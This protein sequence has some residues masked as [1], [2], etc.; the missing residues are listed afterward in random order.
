M[1]DDGGQKISFRC[2]RRESMY[3]KHTGI[4]VFIFLLSFIISGVPKHSTGEVK[5]H[6]AD[7]PEEIMTVKVALG[8]V[9][10][11]PA[12]TFPVTGKL[13]KGDKVK[14][15]GNKDKWYMIRFHGDQVGW[16]HESLFFKTHKAQ[17]AGTGI[18]GQI[19]E[20][21]FEI[22][23]EGGEMVV[24]Q[25]NGYYPPK[26]FAIDKG[27]PRVVCDF[28]DTN[29]GAGIGHLV[30]AKGEIIQQIRI[31]LY[32]GPE[33]RVRVVFDLV[34]REN[35]DYEIQPAFFKDE[36]IYALTIKKVPK[37]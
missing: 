8:N 17:P 32:K 6:Q 27:R 13:R 9:R 11:G 19:K 23:P 35:S 34:S 33:P 1:A 7:R 29:L 26:T 5:S 30:E 20:I 16:A 2:Q 12:L 10:R 3:S 24:F 37:E 36:N 4:V 28:F 15:I 22:V 31:N 21:R 18:S 25:L 14:A